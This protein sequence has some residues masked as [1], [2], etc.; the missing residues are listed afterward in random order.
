MLEAVN[1]SLASLNVATLV[2]MT[3]AIVGALAIIVID[4][5]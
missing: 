2:P 4:L 5:I 3:I 1:V